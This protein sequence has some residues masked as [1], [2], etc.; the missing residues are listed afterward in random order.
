[1]ADFNSSPSPSAAT[2]CSLFEKP[3]ALT[4]A[5]C[6]SPASSIGG[7]LD[8]GV[9]DGCCICLE[10][11][12]VQDPTTVTSCRHEYHLQCILEWSQRSK[13]CPICWQSFVL[14]DPARCITCLFPPL[15]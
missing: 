8:D 3:I 6:S 5:S 12:T 2:A 11:F 14:K 15:L 10:P 1:M 7:V 9:E 4:A 13:E